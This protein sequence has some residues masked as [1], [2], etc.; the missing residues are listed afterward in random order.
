MLISSGLVLLMVPA[1][2]LFYGGASDRPASLKLFRLPLITAA[3]VGVQV[4]ADSQIPGPNLISSS[5]IS[6]AIL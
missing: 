5:G 1:M 3:F 6:G 4:R 2:C